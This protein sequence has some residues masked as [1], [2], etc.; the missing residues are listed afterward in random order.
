MKNI[1][2]KS[3]EKYLLYWMYNGKGNFDKSLDLAKTLD[4]PQLIMYYLV[5]QIESL[6]II[7]IYQGRT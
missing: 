4:D 7:Q 3:D 5:K 2:L 6:K 1:S